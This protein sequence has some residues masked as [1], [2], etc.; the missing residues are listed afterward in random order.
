MGWL[1]DFFEWLGELYD[2]TWPI[3]QWPVE[4]QP[5]WF[6]Q[7]FPVVTLLV[8]MLLILFILADL[9]GFCSPSPSGASQPGRASPIAGV[10]VLHVV[11]YNRPPCTVL[12]MVNISIRP[13]NGQP[14]R[15]AEERPGDAYP[16]PCHWDLR[17]LNGT[18]VSWTQLGG[19]STNG[20]GIPHTWALET[21]STSSG[22]ACS[23][24]FTPTLQVALPP[25]ADTTC[26][27]TLDADA[28][29]TVTYQTE[30]HGII[31]GSP[32]FVTASYPLCLPADKTASQRPEPEPCVG[33]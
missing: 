16:G 17:F 6:R 18:T 26:S 28:T 3:S 2:R 8:V 14:S 30:A 20:W 7:G 27:I 23:H 12:P 29:F 13:A 19:T 31:N 15:N 25:P 4:D 9:L 10:A 33:G 11:A 5:D 1:V 32:Y 24:S 21:S 22:R